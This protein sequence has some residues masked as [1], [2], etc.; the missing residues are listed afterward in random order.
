MKVWETKMKVTRGYDPDQDFFTSEVGTKTFKL[1]GI[2][3]FEK[4]FDSNTT[5]NIVTDKPKG[6]K[7]GTVGFKK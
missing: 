2:T 1:F 5:E 3:V 6:K 4:H 7:N